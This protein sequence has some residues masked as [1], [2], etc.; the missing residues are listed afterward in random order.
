M[1]LTWLRLAAAAFLALHGLVHALGFVAQWQLAKLEGLAYRTTIFNGAIEVGDTGARIVGLAWLVLVP[2]WLVA[3]YGV[4]RARPWALLAVGAVS[5]LAAIVAAAGMPETRL[6]LMLDVA[7][8][9]VAGYIGLIMRR[10][11]TA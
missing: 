9:A 10:P 2:A 7:I 5:V 8:F 4:A 1:A 6:G 11:R 3:A